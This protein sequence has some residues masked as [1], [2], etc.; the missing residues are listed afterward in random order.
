MR[1]RKWEKRG[2]LLL[3]LTLVSALAVSAAPK[4]SGSA[5]R[6]KNWIRLNHKVVYMRVGKSV[7][8]KLKNSKDIVDWKII[9]GKNKIS[10]SKY[11]RTS[12]RVA[13]VQSGTAKVQAKASGKTYTCKLIVKT[14]DGMVLSNTPTP[15][16]GAA[17]TP[18]PRATTTPT[19]VPTPRVA[20]TLTPVPTPRVT[21]TPTPTPTPVPVA[22]N[23]TEERA[24]QM[25]LRN[26][27][28]PDEQEWKN[29][30]LAKL[31]L[32][33]LNLPGTLDMSAFP[34]LEW[35]RC[36]NNLL[37]ELNLTKNTMLE[38]LY[39]N[40]NKLEKL[41][42]SQNTILQT[43]ECVQ[44]QL[45]ELDLKRNSML[46]TLNCSKNLFTSLDFSGNGTLKTLYCTEGKLVSLDLSGNSML[47][48]VDCSFNSIEKLDVSHNV[49]LQSLNCTANKISGVLD[50]TKNYFLNVVFCTQNPLTEID[51]YRSSNFYT[52][53][54][55]KG[56]IVVQKY[57]Y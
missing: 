33:G 15:V 46:T 8:V 27:G 35:F 24:L 25:L 9:A 38:A 56:V 17:P 18:T 21:P 14:G 39:C 2:R 1:N 50:L 20:P 45:T 41:D 34:M 26:Y 7:T 49:M 51:V 43:L 29:G 55:N 54:T 57:N 31:N 47:S 36:D 3:S 40:N 22:H 42:V 11:R 53:D 13:A 16:P 4:Q 5:A 44:N 23:E 19:P 28:V 10:L 6:W 37:T 12:V 32:S 48:L 52:L 30:H